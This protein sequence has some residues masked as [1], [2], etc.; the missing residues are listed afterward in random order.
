MKQPTNVAETILFQ[1]Q[2]HISLKINTFPLFLVNFPASMKRFPEFMPI[3]THAQL[4]FLLSIEHVCLTCLVEP[5]DF[6]CKPVHLFWYPLVICYIAIENDHF[7]SKS[8]IYPLKMHGDFPVRY[9]KPEPKLNPQWAPWLGGYVY[10]IIIYKSP[11]LSHF[12][13][14][15]THHLTYHSPINGFYH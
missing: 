4:S 15:K 7:F 2:K 14:Y 6:H 11:C 1:W 5:T 8:W 9:V 10:G 3:W 12:E 13:A